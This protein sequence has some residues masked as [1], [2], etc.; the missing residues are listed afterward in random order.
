[1]Q[2]GVPCVIPRFVMRSVSI[3]KDET[4]YCF[5]RTE[6]RRARQLLQRIVY[7][8]FPVVFTHVTTGRKKLPA[9]PIKHIKDT[10]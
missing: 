8:L 10:V 2:L 7:S 5:D 3:A 9:A 4:P 6:I 1:M